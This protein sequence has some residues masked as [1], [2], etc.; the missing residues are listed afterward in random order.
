MMVNLLIMIERDYDYDYLMA[1]GYDSDVENQISAYIE[2]EDEFYDLYSRR[3]MY[4][5]K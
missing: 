4:L 5:T 1:L 2:K 3:K